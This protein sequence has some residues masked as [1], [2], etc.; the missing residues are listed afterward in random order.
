LEE[1]EDHMLRRW[2]AALLCLLVAAF[3]CAAH[4]ANFAIARGARVGIVNL[5]DP[6]IADFHDAHLVRDQFLKTRPVTWP[7]DVMLVN[8][9]KDRLAELGLVQVPLAPTPALLRS[10][11]VC[12]VNGSA[13]G[14]SRDC[15]TPFAEL[16]AAERLDVIIVLGPGL[17]SSQ[18]G[19][20]RRELPDYLRG[21]GF[22]TGLQG[23]P[24]GKPSL[25]NMTELLLIG[26][27]AD[28]A[29]LRGLEWGGTYE[30]EWVSFIA[31]TDAKAVSAQQIDQ[32]QP[33]FGEILSRQCG[34]LLE[35]VDVR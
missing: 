29:T 16:A 15:A 25:F 17:N 34:R 27:T 33:L 1:G 13:K 26:V 30:Q 8:A 3:S 14:L 22:A 31:P 9:L 19:R 10:R 4:A 35:Q 32:L 2:D 18:Y 28:G 11:E 24:E 23:A 21:W 5:L 20:R 7:V 6:E 12:I